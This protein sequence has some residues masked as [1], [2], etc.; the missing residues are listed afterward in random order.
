MKV[1]ITKYALTQGI[2]EKDL[3]VSPAYYNDKIFYATEGFYSYRIGTEAFLNIE[4]ARKNAEE[5]KLK[6][7]E[8]LKKQIKKLETLKIVL[9]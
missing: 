6:K 7:I 8:S 1:Y 5:R 3:E 4:D 2:L 9:K